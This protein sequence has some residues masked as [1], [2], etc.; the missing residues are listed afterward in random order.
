[1]KHNLFYTNTFNRI[2]LI[3]TLKDDWDDDGAPAFSPNNL[4]KVKEFIQLYIP[5]DIDTITVPEVN[6]CPDGSIDL[7]WN[8]WI[9]ISGIKTEVQIL[10]NLSF[11]PQY[12]VSY[13]GEIRHRPMSE[14]IKGTYDDASIKNNDL[15]VLLSYLH[16]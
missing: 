13:Y 7:D 12:T 8:T 14:V 5:Q 1:M 10:I 6:P 9:D 4:A 11:D 16:N 15:V 3:R 2:D